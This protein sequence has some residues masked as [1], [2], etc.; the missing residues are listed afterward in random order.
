M[1]SE[2]QEFLNLKVPPARLTVTQTAWFLGFSIHEIPILVAKGLL[3]PLGR[4]AYNGQKFFLT[5]ILE[6]LRR[7]E[8]WFNR[9]SEAVVT[10]WN[11][12]NRRKGQGRLKG[13]NGHP[14]AAAPRSAGAEN[15]VLERERTV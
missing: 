1:Q 5:S 6:E 12:K 10:F 7:N 4:P 13:T 8:R 15:S 2:M 9:A 3:K 11:D 14:R